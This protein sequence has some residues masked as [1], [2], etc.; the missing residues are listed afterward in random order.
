MRSKLVAAILSL[1]IPSVAL[2]G[3]RLP[4]IPV[5]VVVVASAESIGVANATRFIDDAF[6]RMASGRSLGI[7]LYRAKTIEAA[8]TYGVGALD[9]SSRAKALN[10]YVA[11][12]CKSLGVERGLMLFVTGP[13]ISGN[14][15]YSAGQANGIGN[16]GS[17]CAAALVNLKCENGCDARTAA[18]A[19]T[20]I[21]HETG[22]NLGAWH[23]EFSGRTM[24]ADAL[25]A[26]SAA[27]QPLRYSAL[28]IAAIKQ[29]VAKVL[30]G[31][32]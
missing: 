16:F 11:D 1:T 6:N 5:S 7:R 17:K 21:M 10:S 29:R 31:R 9:S 12:H 28:S 30:G 26:A 13:I 15:R 25:R 23:D 3:P 4:G 22:H 8:P 27:L 32:L 2:A 20:A 24:D 18:M 14:S 19:V